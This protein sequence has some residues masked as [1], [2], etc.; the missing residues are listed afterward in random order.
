MMRFEFIIP[1]EL[2]SGDVQARLHTS[3]HLE[4]EP[5]AVVRRT[6]FDSFDWRVHGAAA[7]L[8]GIND[9]KHYR[10]IW[11]ALSVSWYRWSPSSHGSTPCGC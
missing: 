4:A 7:I 8:E 2:E 9:G 10:L 3:M 1:E 5:P 11:R 6:C